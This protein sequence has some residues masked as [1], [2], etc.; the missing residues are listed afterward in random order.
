M[1]KKLLFLILATFSILNAENIKM[2]PE[3]EANWQIELEVPKSS[4]TLPLGE[5]M[6]EVVTPPTLLHTIALPFEANVQKLYVAKYQKV[7]QGDI[8]ADVTGTEWI[9]TQQKAISDV[10]TYK[11]HLQLVQRK[12]V[13]CKEEIIPKKECTSAN[14]EL[15]AS[16]VKLAASKALLKS[17]GADDA[18]L[19]KLFDDLILSH[20]IQLKSI[21]DGRI[22]GLNATPGKSTTPSDAIFI[23]QEKGPLWLE[24]DIE[25]K[26]TEGLTEGENVE[27][28]FNHNTFDTKIL[29]L[30]P[31][32]NPENQ[33][34]RIRFLVP[35]NITLFPGL[36]T[37]AK[38][39][40]KHDTL[41]ITKNAV[42]KIGESQV[43]FYKTNEG[44]TSFPVEILAE[45]ESYYFVKP[46]P[47]LKNKIA[48]TSVAILKNM[49]GSEDE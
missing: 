43:I 21:A 48:V 25:A 45:D 24:S 2:T 33:T 46:S 12:K 13:L 15:E 31:I 30:S 39:V 32:I 11:Y 19:S 26:R 49:L 20:A 17:Y 35:S 27:I 7:S 8:L 22:V 47:E 40:L 16:K 23:L 1:N 10:I 3:Q 6:A 9:E 41:K 18:M 44:Y 28:T 5:F 34:R 4:Q 42:I 29:Q 37:T 36:R 14:A 38:I